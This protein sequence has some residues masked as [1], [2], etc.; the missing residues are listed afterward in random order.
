MTFTDLFIRRPV[1]AIVVSLVILIAGLQSIRALSVRQYPRSDIATIRVATTYVGA[2][3]DLVRGFIT[4]PLERV[5]ASA[6]GIDYVECHGTGT[7]L[8]D[9][10]EVA[11]LADAFAA[12]AQGPA[13]CLIGSVKTNIG[14]LDTAAGG[15]SLIKTALALHHAEIP[16][17][18]GFEPPLTAALALRHPEHVPE[19]V[20]AEGR[21]LLTRDAGRR[22][23]NLHDE[24]ARPTEVRARLRTAL[25]HR[26]QPDTDGYR[27][28]ASD[29]STS[30]SVLEAYASR[31]HQRNGAGLSLYT[32]RGQQ[33]ARGDGAVLPVPEAAVVD[34]AVSSEGLRRAVADAVPALTPFGGPGT[35][36]QGRPGPGGNGIRG[37]RRG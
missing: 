11:A 18:L 28:A 27:M 35:R 34:G 5:I 6:D 12:T 32:A 30:G 2:N 37:P 3:A 26:A 1:L 10:I 29:V 36:V 14:H 4:T 15:A 21:R 7:A 13:Q 33:L 19:V 31:L 8:G 24:G 17:S 9:P 22:L 20:A 25:Q 23:R 16:P